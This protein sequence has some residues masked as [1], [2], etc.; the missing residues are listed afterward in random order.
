[1]LAFALSKSAA[2]LCRPVRLR[3]GGGSVSLR[4]VAVQDAGWKRLVSG[5]TRTVRAIPVETGG[6][7][8]RLSGTFCVVLIF[9]H[10]GTLRC[11]GLA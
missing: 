2:S 6:V 11:A 5:E 1:M 7:R 8:G 3:L 9:M 10:A 4:R